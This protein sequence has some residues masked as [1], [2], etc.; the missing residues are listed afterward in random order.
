MR[1]KINVYMLLLLLFITHMSVAEK[2]PEMVDLLKA[3]GAK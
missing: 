2:Y 1:N 3:N